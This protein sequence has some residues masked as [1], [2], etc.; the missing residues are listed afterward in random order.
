[1]TLPVFTFLGFASFFAFLRS[2][3]RNSETVNEVF[4]ADD[5]H[6]VIVTYQK[7]LWVG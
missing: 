1:M 4:L 6:H 3:L 2:N 5:L 7:S